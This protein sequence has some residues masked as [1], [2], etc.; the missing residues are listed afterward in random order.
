MTNTRNTE[1]NY[2]IMGHVSKTL[3]HFVR[4]SAGEDP[5]TI[6][7]EKIFSKDSDTGTL[8]C[9]PNNQGLGHER[10]IRFAEFSPSSGVNDTPSSSETIYE[11]RCVCFA[12]IPINFLPIH[13]KKYNGVALGFQRRNLEI[14]RDLRPVWYIPSIFED[15]LPSYL[16]ST[17]PKTLKTHVKI[18]SENQERDE[19]FDVI[20]KEREWR[21]PADFE[22]SIYE[23]S[24]LIFR[25]RDEVRRAIEHDKV[26]KMIALG[27]SILNFHDHFEERTV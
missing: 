7:L 4:S 13:F 19:D 26:K 27:V 9:N 5:V 18:P 21:K 1:T 16:S 20:Y 25:N 24:C 11:P 10:T 22:F 8:L 3:W 12:D 17:N 15:D 6:L 23:V 14:Q 2:E